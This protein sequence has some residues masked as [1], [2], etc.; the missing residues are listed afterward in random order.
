MKLSFISIAGQDYGAL[1]GVQVTLLQEESTTTVLV[2]ITN[3]EDFEPDP[4]SFFGNLVISPLSSNIAQVSVPQATVNIVDDDGEW[5]CMKCVSLALIITECL[6][7]Y[8]FVCI[9]TL[10][11]SL[12]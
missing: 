1:S 3:D 6:Q 4:E 12:L 2:S 9:H 7:S 8:L 5:E 11:L 10:L